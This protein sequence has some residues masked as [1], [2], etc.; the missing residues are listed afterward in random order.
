ME[1]RFLSS[2]TCPVKLQKRDGELEALFGYASVFYNADD[3]GTEFQIYPDLVER[4]MPTAFDRCL[5]E[6]ADIACLFNHDP[7]QVLGRSSSGTMRLKCD[8]RG[9]VYQTVPGDTSIARDVCAMVGRGDV[10]G[11]SFSFSVVKQ[12]FVTAEDMD[13]RE[14]HDVDLYD[15]GPVTFPAYDSSTAG[16]R[17]R[18][19]FAVPDEV[20][21]AYQAWKAEQRGAVPYAAGP[22]YQGDSWDADAA[23]KR[24]RAWAGGAD[25]MDWTQYKKA[26]AWC[27]SEKSD[28]FGAYK[29]P[30]HDIQGGKLVVHRKGV[31]AAMGAALGARGGTSIPEADRKKVYNHLAQHYKAMDMDPPEYHSQRDLIVTPRSVVLARARTLEMELGELG[32]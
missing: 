16:L 7:N 22:I 21:A 11:S 30:H 5:R 1:R 9:L 29:F 4:I 28:S 10:R 12:A 24:L 26:F 14:V 19:F 25:S 23:L 31:I 3:P 8:K 32:L 15:C 13:V 6:G 2:A 20:R 18:D 27:E 17:S